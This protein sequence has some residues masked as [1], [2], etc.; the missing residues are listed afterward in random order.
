VDA[1]ATTEPL[2]ERGAELARIESALV[3]ARAGRGRFLM[4]EGPAG[5]GKTALLAETRTAATQAAMRVPPSRGTE[6]ESDF[7]FGVVRRLFEPPLVEASELERAE[8]LQGRCRRGGRP[9]RTCRRTHYNGLAFPGVGPSFAILHGPYFRS[10]IPAWHPSWSAASVAAGQLAAEMRHGDVGQPCH[11]AQVG[12]GGSGQSHH[13]LAGGGFAG[14]P[15]KQRVP[16]LL[17]VAVSRVRPAC[18]EL[19]KGRRRGDLDPGG[20]QRDR[21]HRVLRALM[22]NLFVH[23]YVIRHVVRPPIGVFSVIRV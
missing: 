19:A 6:L 13:Q 14:D 1:A 20:V 17:G 21:G 16:N 5:I 22:G 8:L 4:I 7:A 2:L 10:L 15:A 9:D 11:V 3:E 12:T 23:R 18:D